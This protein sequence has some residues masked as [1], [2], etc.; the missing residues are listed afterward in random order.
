MKIKE[1]ASGEV[2]IEGIT[3]ITLTGIDELLMILQRGEALRYKRSTILNERSSRSHTVVEF[4]IN[5]QVFDE[6]GD[7]VRGTKLILCDLA[8]IEK[9]TDDKFT[10]KISMI[11]SNNINKSLSALGRQ[12]K[13]TQSCTG[14][15]L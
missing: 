12:A 11:E 13:L 2:H 6:N 7:L 14:S 9:F 5:K 15:I 10:N 4:T 3:E 8:G 1:T